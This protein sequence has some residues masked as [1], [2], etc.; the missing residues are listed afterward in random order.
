M[1]KNV[2]VAII[3]IDEEKVRDLRTLPSSHPISAIPDAL[4]LAVRTIAPPAAME[5]KGIYAVSAQHREEVEDEIEERAIDFHEYA[6]DNGD[7]CIHPK[8]DQHPREAARTPAE[9][10][11]ASWS[12]KTHWKS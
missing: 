3:E 7:R 5:L 1:P 4:G 2:I 11:T 12:T 9:E 6:V 10:E 8:C